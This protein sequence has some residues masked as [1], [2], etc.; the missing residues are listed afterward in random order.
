MDSPAPVPPAPEP[1]PP[2]AASPTRGPSTHRVLVEIF[3]D[4]HVVRTLVIPVATTLLQLRNEIA[5]LRFGEAVRDDYGLMVRGTSD[6]LAMTSELTLADV[7]APGESTLQL[8]A[9]S[10][11]QLSVMARSGRGRKA[12]AAAGGKS[13]CGLAGGSVLFWVAVG[14]FAALVVGVAAAAVAAR[15]GKKRPVLR[16]SPGRG[17]RR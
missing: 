8:T 9:I 12:K 2:A 6:L 4:E 15:A 16:R 7:I 10:P 3:Q 14:L 11:A 1:A 17:S 5:G 13:S